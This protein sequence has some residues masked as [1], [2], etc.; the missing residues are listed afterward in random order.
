MRTFARSATVADPRHPPGDGL[1]ALFHRV[2]VL[3][4]EHPQGFDVL[5]AG[6]LLAASMVWQ[7]RQPHLGVG[8]VLLQVALIAPLAWRRA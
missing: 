7:V 1:G 8:P 6:T 5:L 3:V 2:R 4:S